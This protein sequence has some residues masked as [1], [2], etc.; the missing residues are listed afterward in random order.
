MG[1]SF[2]KFFDSENNIIGSID[3][4][5][6]LVLLIV[7]FVVLLI[8]LNKD[9][10]IFKA[11]S[12]LLILAMGVLYYIDIEKVIEAKKLLP[13]TLKYGVGFYISIAG[14]VAMVI[15][16]FVDLFSKQKNEYL[17]IEKKDNN[18]YYYND[19]KDDNFYQNDNVNDP[20]KPEET[21][22][23]NQ[24]KLS[25]LVKKSDDN[26]DNDDKQNN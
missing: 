1:L 16:G 20:V 23:T 8:R 9:L 10:P 18:N 3:W 7:L 13:E 26:I 19:K 5:I 21:T 4:K 2:I 17:E 24:I 6:I 14:L 22:N 15:I 25:D 12:L 11:A